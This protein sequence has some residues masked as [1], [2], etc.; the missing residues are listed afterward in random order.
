MDGRGHAQYKEN[1]EEVG[2]DYVADGQAA[3]PLAGRDDGGDQLGQGG[4]DGDDGKPDEG[5]AQPQAFRDAAGPVY[6]HVAAHDD[7]GQSADHK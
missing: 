3:F 5:L 1:V 2:A 7:P 6:H 4:A